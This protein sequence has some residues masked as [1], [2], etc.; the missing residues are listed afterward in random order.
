MVPTKIHPSQDGPVFIILSLEFANTCHYQPTSNFFL[1]TPLLPPPSFHTPFLSWLLLPTEYLGFKLSSLVAFRFF[2]RKLM[3]VGSNTCKIIHITV[4]FPRAT[5]FKWVFP[6]R[7]DP[8][9]RAP[10]IGEVSGVGFLPHMLFMPGYHLAS[11]LHSH[12]PPGVPCLWAPTSRA[13]PADV[14]GCLRLSKPSRE[15]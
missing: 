1:A 9:G 4:S 12:P 10:A 8:A 3:S 5:Y 11:S 2:R 6:L 14:Y 7:Q 13:I 15:K